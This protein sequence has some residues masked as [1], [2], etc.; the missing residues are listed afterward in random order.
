MPHRGVR[1]LAQA[2]FG[3]LFASG[4]LVL[5]LVPP[6]DAAGTLCGTVRD[7]NTHL[8]VARA[9]IFVRTT[10]GAYTGFYGASDMNGAF[11][12]DGLPP[13][14]YDVEVR[15]DE[16]LA[17][18]F[19]NIVVNDNATGVVDATLAGLALAPP[20]PNPARDVVSLRFHG[21]A[22]GPVTVEVLDTSGRVVKAWRAPSSSNREQSFAWDLRDETGRPI[23]AGRYFVRLR[24]DPSSVVR[25]FVLLR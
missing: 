5:G 13:G 4:F 14:T 8:P 24:S 1:R 17:G 15:V 19:K 22:D 18:Y 3:A 21:P 6:A 11:C 2:F 23:P 9:G 10:A 7:G 25:S 12:I 20:A 16:Y